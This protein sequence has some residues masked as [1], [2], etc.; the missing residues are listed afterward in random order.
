MEGGP[1]RKSQAC[2]ANRLVRVE[3]IWD[4]ELLGRGFT[5]KSVLAEITHKTT[6]TGS[7]RCQASHI[8]PC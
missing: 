4:Y 6:F 8:G 1:T 2:N 5:G 3:Q 7:T